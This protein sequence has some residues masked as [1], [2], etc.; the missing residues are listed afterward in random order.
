MVDY[1][2][3][4]E[5]SRLKVRGGGRSALQWVPVT[6]VFVLATL[7]AG[8]SHLHWPF[9]HKPTP[10]PPEVHELDETSD[11]GAPAT[12]P[13]YWMRNTL[14]VDLQGA[15]GTGSVTL[16]PREHT[17]WPV[18]IAVKVMPGSVGEIEVRAAQ[19]TV[20]PVTP[21]GAKPVVLELSPSIYTFK[22]K[23]MVL[24][25]GPNPAPAE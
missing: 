14:I 8:C 17:T 2:G 7:L 22:T 11:G 1:G 20:F 25:W 18:R 24:S 13:Q 23:Q 16:K 9:R 10:P 12:F 4:C 6:G 5:N 19:R 3:A 15:S 21:A